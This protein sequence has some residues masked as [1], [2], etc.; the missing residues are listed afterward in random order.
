MQRKARAAAL[1]EARAQ[2]AEA[3][4]RAQD[5]ERR[6]ESSA[7][8]GR[9]QAASP[10]EV[11]RDR[12]EADARRA[13]VRALHLAVARLEGDRDLQE[14]ERKARLARLDREA[15]ELEGEAAVESA[16]LRRLEYELALRTVRASVGGRVGEAAEVQVGAVVRAADKLGAV[17]P[18]GER[19]AVALFPAAAVGRLRP[20]QPARLRLDGFPW[21]QYGTLSATVSDVATEPS[22][23]RV[24]VELT[25]GD[26]QEARVP[27]EHG[28]TGSAEVEVERLAPAV[29]ALR[30]AGQLLADR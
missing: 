13:G 23:G 16:A 8:A 4:L 5:A 22:G 20:G 11:R 9:D 25:L 3:E 24:R 12:A 10:E 15:A 17:V 19:R 26:R 1:V 29:L 18:A 21:A 28:L 27:V 2:V 7:R 30:A 14:R 6:A